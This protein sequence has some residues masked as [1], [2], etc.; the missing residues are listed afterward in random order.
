MS[1]QFFMC[2]QIVLTSPGRNYD[3]FLEPGVNVIKGP[4]FTG[5]SSIME[6][7]DYVCGAKAPLGYPEIKKCS[8]VLVHLSVSGEELTIRRSLANSNAKSIIHYG[9]MGD[10]LAGTS[11]LKEVSW[12]H[13]K[14]KES[15]SSELLER[16]GL[17][18]IEIKT[19]PTQDASDTNLFS[20]R[21]LLRMLYIRQSRMGSNPGFF[22]NDFT[23]KIKWNAAFE[24]L[25]GLY[26]AKATHL[27]KSLKQAKEEK[28]ALEEDLAV[29][30]KFLADSKVPSID[31][32]TKLLREIVAKKTALEEA[33][34]RQKDEEIEQLGIKSELLENREDL[35]ASANRHSAQHSE[36][37]RALT[38]LGKLRVQYERELSQLE[39]LKESSTLISPI[40]I[41][42]CPACLQAIPHKLDEHSCYTCKRQ[43][44]QKE[45]ELVIESQLRSL[46]FR[47]T[48]LE[49]YTQELA[50]Q[51]NSLQNKMTE[52]LQGIS[53]IDKAIETV[54]KRAVFPKDR[55]LLE[56]AALIAMVEKEEEQCRERLQ[57]RYRARGDYS[58]LL[59]LQERINN[60]QAQLDNTRKNK[61]SS[62]EVIAELSIRFSKI[63]K[64]VK[65]P[66]NVDTARLDPQHYLPIVREQDYKEIR[67]NG[68]IALIQCSFHLAMLEYSLEKQSFFPK[69][70]MLDSPLNHVGRDNSD[71][72]F[73][74]QKIVDAFYAYL[75]SL[76]QSHGSQMQLLVCDNSP[77]PS[78]KH[79]I[80]IEY[81][82]ERERGRYGLIEDEFPPD[83]QTVTN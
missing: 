28:K 51:R 56:Q 2:R 14:G 31:E 25:H 10:A 77:P 21:D 49:N 71:P 78:A 30:Q 73:R 50:K 68:A 69:F 42:R 57:L 62:T 83:T 19:A 34:E 46:K 6:L 18:D 17:G 22:E 52:V 38:Q 79:L 54:R 58:N 76:Q 26:D 64:T 81:T 48:D 9:T 16:L 20:M 45:E 72:E 41:S 5:K 13:E 15:L 63:L 59:S 23:D 27:S 74:D 40:P 33:S 47:I 61:P 24:I 82:G 36:L 39:F 70:L 60:L 53:E 35:I 55:Q 12:K 4:I 80:R 65:F 75:S 44:P 3:I 37:E 67:S 29:S 7:I 32:L 43:L 11:P 8:D 66:W 1:G